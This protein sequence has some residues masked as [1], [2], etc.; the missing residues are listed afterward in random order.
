MTEEITDNSR[1]LHNEETSICAIILV[2]ESHYIKEDVLEPKL[3]THK[4]LAEHYR[5]STWS[6]RLR[7]DMD[8][9]QEQGAEENI[10]TR[11]R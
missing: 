7:E 11:E 2:C 8:C 6:V 4:T 1:K 5:G 9:I 3:G 10:R